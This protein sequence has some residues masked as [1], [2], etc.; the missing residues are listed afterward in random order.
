MAEIK[1]TSDAALAALIG[2]VNA[3]GADDGRKFTDARRR[4]AVI[5]LAG[6]AKLFRPVL[7]D[8]FSLVY[9]GAI[10]PER[11]VVLLSCHIDHP[12]KAAELFLKAGKGGLT[13]TLDNSV[14]AGL[15]LDLLRRGELPDNVLAAFT[16]NEERGMRGAK[17]LIAHLRRGALKKYA[18]GLGAVLTLDVTPDNAAMPVSLENVAPNKRL[19]ARL[20]FEN[21]AAAAAW[22]GARLKAAGVP[23]G[24]LLKALPDESFAYAAAGLSALSFGLPVAPRAGRGKADVH[25]PAGVTCSFR[26]M[27]LWQ[28]GLAAAAAAIAG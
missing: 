1:K 5:A 17:A 20:G 12:F 25:D 18:A 14:C 2:A 7:D 15:L 28:K 16:G 21:P 3:P 27:R 24:T 8:G 9:G 4:Q 6:R 13:G 26:H 10:D 23:Y 11:T 19:R 22:V